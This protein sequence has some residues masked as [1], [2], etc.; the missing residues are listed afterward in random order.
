[1]DIFSH[2]ENLPISNTNKPQEHETSWLFWEKKGCPHLPYYLEVF[3]SKKWIPEYKLLLLVS[4]MTCTYTNRG[5]HEEQIMCVLCLWFS[6]WVFNSTWATVVN[7]KTSKGSTLCTL[8]K[9]W[10]IPGGLISPVHLR[11]SLKFLAQDGKKCT[12][13]TRP[14]LHSLYPPLSSPH[15]NL[16]SNK[17]IQCSLSYL[18]SLQRAKKVP[19]LIQENRQAFHRR[20]WR[21][22]HW[23]LM[24]EFLHH[25]L[26]NI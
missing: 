20:N 23:L 19:F 11:S 15:E 17:K 22:L 3:I 26:S 18:N 7:Q 8:E 1:M 6:W 25:T 24:E 14:C 13:E 10:A 12:W 2:L 9:E 4:E 16:P 5:Y 21:F